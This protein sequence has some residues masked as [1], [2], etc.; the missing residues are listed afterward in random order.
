MPKS[1]LNHHS[2][3]IILILLIQAVVDE[4]EARIASCHEKGVEDEAGYERAN[5]ASAAARVL[6]GRSS[7]TPATSRHQLFRLFSTVT[8]QNHI[9]ELVKNIYSPC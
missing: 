7:A 2:W 4:L 1:R 8:S 3:H 5:Q 6:A 9:F